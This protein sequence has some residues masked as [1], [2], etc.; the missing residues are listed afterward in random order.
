MKN[1]N[2]KWIWT[3]VLAMS[4]YA[5]QPDDEFIPEPEPEPDAT[6]Y[7][8]FE[9]NG[10]V[11]D[12]EE[13]LSGS[14]SGVQLNYYDEANGILS[15]TMYNDVALSPEFASFSIN[16]INLDQLQVPATLILDSTVTTSAPTPGFWWTDA[17][18]NS[19]LSKGKVLI[20]PMPWLTVTI[21]SK[22]DDIIQGTFSGTLYSHDFSE[23]KTVSNGKFKVPIT[24]E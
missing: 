7:I 2:N 21:T 22:N 5:C 3:G 18:N 8:D 6:Y 16:H 23:R 15:L 1:W 14:W 24:R 12:Y 9:A 20:D 4:L 19:Y 17:D 10:V 13:V 11:Y